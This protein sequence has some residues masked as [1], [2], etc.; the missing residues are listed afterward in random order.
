MSLTC[1]GCGHGTCWLLYEFASYLYVGKVFP[2]S[3]VQKKEKKEKNIKD[4]PVK[5]TWNSKFPV[6]MTFIFCLGVSLD[7]ILSKLCP[8]PISGLYKFIFVNHI[9][10]QCILLWLS[11]C[12]WWTYATT[13]SEP[14]WMSCHEVI[15]F[16]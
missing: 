1:Q 10:I 3:L 8:R 5:W 6:G 11:V 9:Y 14:N 16:N 4:M 12:L 15:K 7:I 2:Q 13:V